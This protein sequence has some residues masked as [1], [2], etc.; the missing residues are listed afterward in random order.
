MHVKIDLASQ[1]LT[2]G[3]GRTVDFPIDPFSKQCLLEGVD[4]LG[5]MQKQE[6][7]IAAYEAGRLGSVN[8]LA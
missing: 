8:T 6:P 1:K 2:L 4:E 7:E 5:F 3:D